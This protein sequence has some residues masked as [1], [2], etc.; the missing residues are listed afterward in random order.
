MVRYGP[1]VPVSAPVSAGGRTAE[2]VWSGPAPA[3]TRGPRWRK[4]AGIALT[5]ALLAASAVLLYLR[6]YHPPLRVRAAAITGQ[7]RHGCTVTVT[8]RITTNGG[9][10]TV[11]YRWVFTPGRS[12]PPPL[13]QSL[14]AGQHTADVTATLEGTGHGSATQT[15]TLDVL[16]PGHA[17]ASAV[18]VVSC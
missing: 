12:Q 5:V 4:T 18:V 17:A 8:G 13:G 10:G 2:H 9:P 1:G 16:A 3:P 6:F 14:S 7:A 15:A 11:T